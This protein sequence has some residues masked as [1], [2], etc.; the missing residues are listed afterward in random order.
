MHSSTHSPSLPPAGPP[1]CSCVD[2]SLERRHVGQH[3]SPYS[4]YLTYQ[5]YVTSVCPTQPPPRQ[6]HPSFHHSRR[7]AT[8]KP[9]GR[10]AG[11]NYNTQARMHVGAQRISGARPKIIVVVVRWHLVCVCVCV[12]VCVF[13]SPPHPRHTPPGT[14]DVHPR[15]GAVTTW[16]QNAKIQHAWHGSTETSERLWSPG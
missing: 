1:I 7:Q 6:Q 2:S 15:A 4:A 8:R 12:C 9:A 10:Q 3:P 11:R 14:R 16:R 5:Q 13:A